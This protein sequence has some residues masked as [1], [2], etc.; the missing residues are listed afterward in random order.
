[1]AA[2]LWVHIK[3]ALNFTPQA[4]KLTPVT[5]SSSSVTGVSF[6]SSLQTFCKDAVVAQN[7]PCGIFY[8]TV[9]SFCVSSTSET[10]AFKMFL[11]FFFSLF[12]TSLIFLCARC[13]FF[14][15]KKRFEFPDWTEEEE[16]GFKALAAAETANVLRGSDKLLDALCFC[17]A[18]FLFFFW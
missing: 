3:F 17:I 12:P 2:W 10:A 16:E 11:P 6:T 7:E 5:S 14:F 18:V 4:T 15:F 9:F 1:M 8:I 13:G